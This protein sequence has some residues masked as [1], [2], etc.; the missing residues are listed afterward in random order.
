MDEIFKY[1]K[2][3]NDDYYSIL[4]CDENSSE[5][6][7]ISEFKIKALDYHPD[8]NPDDPNSVERFQRL[9]RAKEILTEPT[10]RKQYDMWRRSGLTIPFDQWRNLSKDNHCSMHWAC[11]KQKDLM[12][13]HKCDSESKLADK[14]SYADQQKSTFSILQTENITWEREPGNEVLQKFRNYQI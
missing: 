8:K 3:S 1:K 10:T 5:E 7:I 4:G 14:K 12:L 13:D 2:D 6:Q 9:Q 11:K